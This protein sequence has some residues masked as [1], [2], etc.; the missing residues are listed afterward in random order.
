MVYNCSLPGDFLADAG[1][2]GTKIHFLMT[3]S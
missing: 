3:I 1:V 2:L